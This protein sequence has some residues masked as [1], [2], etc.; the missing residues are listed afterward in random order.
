MRLNDKSFERLAAL[1]IGTIAVAFGNPAGAVPASIGAAGLIR[2]V[3]VRNQQFGPENPRI[4]AKLRE[5]VRD[6]YSEFLERDADGWGANAELVAADRALQ[7]ALNSSQFDR[8]SLAKAAVSSAGFVETATEIVMVALAERRPDAFGAGQ[9]GTIAHRYARDVIRAGLSAAFENENYYRKLEPR[10]VLEIAGVLGEVREDVHIANAKLDR[11]ESMLAEVLATLQQPAPSAL[12]SQLAADFG[13]DN[14]AASDEE[15]RT[16]L[17]EKAADYARLQA[18]ISSLAAADQRVGNLL[19]AAQ[20]A[21]D[22]GN[23]DEA[24]ARL[25]DAEEMQQAEHTLKEIRKQSETRRVRGESMLMKGA[26]EAAAGHYAKAAGFFDQFDEIEGASLRDEFA[27]TLSEHS[28]RYGGSGMQH[29]IRFYRLNLETWSEA[30][31]PLQ[32]AATQN[33]LG[34]ALR[35]Q[36]ARLAGAVGAALLGEAV[37][38]YRAALRVYTEAD[39][40]LNWAMTQNNHGN[41]LRA[42]GQGGVANAS[43]R[44]TA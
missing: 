25:A 1:S 39:H 44:A 11:Q 20:A 41:A 7:E 9:S 27:N 43:L 16:F 35:N 22:A 40:P 32:W 6:G 12:L 18:Q 13:H 38:A 10:F 31:H 8:E 42:I 15:F 3:M 14:P 2:D 24:D 4:L 37:A 19:A 34:A 17:R 23:F 30:D 36:G 5:K 33:N 26:V 28:R 29:A 21:L